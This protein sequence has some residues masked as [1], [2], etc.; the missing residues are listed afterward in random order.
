MQMAFLWN[1]KEELINGEFIII[2]DF[3]ENYAF[4]V[5]D[6]VQSFHWNNSQAMVYPFVV[7][8]GEDSKL[9]HKSFVVISDYNQHD[10]VAV[11]FSKLD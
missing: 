8:Y 7:Y 5:Q 11:I 2:G 6:A 9:T 3:A 10:T 4:I 1:K